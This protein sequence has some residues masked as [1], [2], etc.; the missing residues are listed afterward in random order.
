MSNPSQADK[1]PYFSASL[2]LINRRNQRNP[3]LNKNEHWDL[4]TMSVK[5]ISKNE[6]L[7]TFE[8]LAVRVELLDEEQRLLI[9]LFQAGQSY[10]AI[11][12]MAGA[13]EA[14][15]ARR[16]RKIVRRISDD[17]FITA[18]SGENTQG[19]QAKILKERFVY[20][21]TVRQIAKNTGLSKY[22]IRKIIKQK[23]VDRI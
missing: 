21:K 14:T 15:I 12:V 17:R 19:Q 16:L 9:R 7:D 13:N 4:F 20:G 5:N 22:E 10:K 11:A 2:L 3:R 23:T 6:L 18:L 8:K 1:Y